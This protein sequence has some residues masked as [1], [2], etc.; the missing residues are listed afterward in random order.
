MD[1]K[2]AE[3]LKSLIDDLNSKSDD[4]FFEELLSANIVF[5]DISASSTLTNAIY[6]IKLTGYS[7]YDYSIKTTDLLCA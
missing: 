6:N 7:S 2:H 1:K 3:L 5:D 4:E